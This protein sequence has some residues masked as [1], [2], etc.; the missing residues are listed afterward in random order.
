MSVKKL[1]LIS[2][3]TGLALAGSSVALAGGP[4]NMRSH[5]AALDGLYVGAGVT[6][7]T[8][9]AVVRRQANKNDNAVEGLGFRAQL[10]YGAFVK[11]NFYLG[12]EAAGEITN[13][14][15]NNF[16]AGSTWNVEDKWNFTLAVVPGFRLASNIL[17]YAKFGYER[18][19]LDVASRTQSNTSGVNGAVYGL[20]FAAA[21][22]ND[23]DLRM[24]YNYYKL[25]KDEVTLNGNGGDVA[26]RFDVIALTLNYHLTM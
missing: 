6:R 25:D 9:Y 4:D 1:L 26:P 2:A 12:G 10:G 19:E 13:A 24:E 7:N 23:L 22:R 21:V 18:A 8:G 16:I 11:G 20:G 5:A 14:K 3:A 17:A 15:T